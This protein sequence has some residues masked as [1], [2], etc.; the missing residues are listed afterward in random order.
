MARFP[1]SAPGSGPRR[2]PEACGHQ[3]GQVQAAH[4]ESVRKPQPLAWKGVAL[5]G[6]G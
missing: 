4:W 1:P 2:K 5:A 3:A 6:C